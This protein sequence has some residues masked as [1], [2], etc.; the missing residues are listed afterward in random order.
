MNF[1]LF[2]MGRSLRELDA[3][4][5][6]DLSIS[7]PMEALMMAPHT[8]SLHL[9][10]HTLSSYPSVHTLLFTPSSSHQALMM[11]LFGN[12]VPESWELGVVL[13]IW[14]AS[15]CQSSAVNHR[16][17]PNDISISNAPPSIRV[18]HMCRADSW[19][20]VIFSRGCRLPTKLP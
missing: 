20:I 14:V 11:A 9:H 13:H 17:P 10:L 1:L 4:L 2:E 3:G 5:R 18:N 7:E 16:T 19:P 6:G 8:P 12:K 15:A